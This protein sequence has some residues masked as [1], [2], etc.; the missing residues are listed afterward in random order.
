M[1]RHQALPGHRPGTPT[2]GRT[3]DPATP[4]MRGAA[5]Y[6]HGDEM[7]PTG[8]DDNEHPRNRRERDRQAWLAALAIARYCDRCPVIARCEQLRRREGSA[9]TGVWAGI[10]ITGEPGPRSARNRPPLLLA[11]RYLA[12]EDVEV[13][14]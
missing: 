13:P 14:A 12:G 4:S 1:T 8:N 10:W 2:P 6:G 9:A 11:R 3:V 5:C 7:F